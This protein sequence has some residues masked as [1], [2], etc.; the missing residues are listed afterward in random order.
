MLPDDKGYFG[1]YGGRF[2]PE[3]LIPTLDELALAFNEAKADKSFWAE[4][5]SLSRDYSG[6]PGGYNQMVF[7]RLHRDKLAM[8]AAQI[9]S[10]CYRPIYESRQVL[11]QENISF[12]STVSLPIPASRT[13]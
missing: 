6:N 4:F 8:A 5:N 1:N 3:T 9:A 2:V 13:R 11:R 7:R 12:P 10:G